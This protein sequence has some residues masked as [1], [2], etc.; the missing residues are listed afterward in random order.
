MKKTKSKNTGSGS[1]IPSFHAGCKEGTL[2]IGDL[3]VLFPP[4][5]VSLLYIQATLNSWSHKSG[6]DSHMILWLQLPSQVNIFCW[7]RRYCRQK[8]GQQHERLEN[9]IGHTSSTALELF[10]R[11]CNRNMTTRGGTDPFSLDWYICHILLDSC[12]MKWIES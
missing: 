5:A 9:E 4:G 7:W 2:T 1:S 11:T 8:L 12:L 6:M 3:A 10:D